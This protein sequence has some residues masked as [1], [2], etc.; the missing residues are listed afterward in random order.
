MAEKDD[1]GMFEL[2]VNIAK[3]VSTLALLG[4]G[5]YVTIAIFTGI[6]LLF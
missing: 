1:Y 4:V 5:W 6:G 2:A 3:G